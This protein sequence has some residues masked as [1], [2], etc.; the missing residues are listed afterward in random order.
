[1]DRFRDLGD[2]IR[3]TQDEHV[4]SAWARKVAKDPNSTTDADIQGMRDAGYT[5]ADIVGITTYVASGPD[6]S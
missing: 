2:D 6:N 4:L 3:L 5:D 1:M